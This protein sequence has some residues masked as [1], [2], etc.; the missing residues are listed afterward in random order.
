MIMHYGPN[1]SVLTTERGTV[2]SMVYSLDEIISTS[3]VILPRILLVGERDKYR[4]DA[5]LAGHGMGMAAWLGQAEEIQRAAKLRRV[6]RLCCTWLSVSS[7][8]RC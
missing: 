7:Q 5:R 4:G 3:L 8:L 6:M 1:R 2:P